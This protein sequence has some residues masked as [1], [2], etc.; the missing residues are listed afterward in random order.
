MQ[1]AI[2]KD[3]VKELTKEL[4]IIEKGHIE[5]GGDCH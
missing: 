4:D 2:L 3:E 5:E 1:V